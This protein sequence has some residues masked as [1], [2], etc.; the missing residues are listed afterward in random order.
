MR[1]LNRNLCIPIYDRLNIMALVTFLGGRALRGSYA[2][3]D[4]RGARWATTV[5]TYPLGVRLCG[6]RT[7]AA[8]SLR[9]KSFCPFPETEISRIGI[10]DSRRQ[11][12]TQ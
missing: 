1:R 11:R 8:S 6:I 2:R 5:A 12:L 10:A 9:R 3:T 7:F 4:L